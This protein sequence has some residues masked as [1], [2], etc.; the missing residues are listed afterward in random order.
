M[1]F[2]VVRISRRCQAC[3]LGVMLLFLLEEERQEPMA[4]SSRERALTGKSRRQPLQQE[5][6]LLLHDTFFP[7]RCAFRSTGLAIP[8]RKPTLG[9]NPCEE[10][11]AIHGAKATAACRGPG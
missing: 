11:V 4:N 2:T 8:A 3:Q 9:K 1:G 10:L 7:S 6:R 5:H